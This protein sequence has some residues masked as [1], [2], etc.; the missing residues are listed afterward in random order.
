MARATRAFLH[1]GAMKTGTTFLQHILWSQRDLAA[2]HGLLLPGT[3]AVH[4]LAMLDLR[5]V[6]ERSNRPERVPGSWAGVVDEA[7]AWDGDVLVSD[8]LLSRATPAQASRAVADLRGTG[9][10]V[11]VVLTVRDWARRLP[12]HWQEYV[13]ARGLLSFEEYT[14]RDP[15]TGAFL[16]PT[17]QEVTDVVGRVDIWSGAGARVHVVTVPPSGAD[18]GLLWQ[19]FAGVLGLAADAFSTDVPRNPSLGLEQTE[20]LRMVNSA[21]LDRLPRPGPYDGAVKTALARRVLAGRPGTP[22]VLGGEDLAWARR[23]GEEEIAA[24]AARD[25]DLVGDLADLVVP[26][27]GPAL[28]SMATGVDEHRMLA[29]AVASLTDLLV[30]EHGRRDELRRTRT[31]PLAPPVRAGRLARLRRLLSGLDRS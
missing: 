11:H 3:R 30:S 27:Q 9:R 24:L 6:A 12:A 22:L 18:P 7:R 15:R 17:L 16:N 14:R 1:V 8:E 29:E 28:S 25:V 4:R 5:E 21:L 19:R 26:S 10:E 31:A 2:G 20:L 13:K 23:R